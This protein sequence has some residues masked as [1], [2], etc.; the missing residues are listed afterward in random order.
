[1]NPDRKQEKKNKNGTRKEKTEKNGKKK[2]KK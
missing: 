2:E 1:L